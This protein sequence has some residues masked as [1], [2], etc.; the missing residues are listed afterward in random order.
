MIADTITLKANNVNANYGR[1]YA[2]AIGSGS[3]TKAAYI[4][5]FN[6]YMMDKE[7]ENVLD[8]LSQYYTVTPLDAGEFSNITINA[9]LAPGMIVTM[10]F[11]VQQYEVEGYGK[12]VAPLVDRKRRS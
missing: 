7:A 4:T 6:S 2:D 3:E 1:S 12:T 5:K 11:E 9:P 10:D 8:M